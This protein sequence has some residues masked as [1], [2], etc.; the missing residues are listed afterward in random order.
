VNRLSQ[1]TRARAK[2]AFGY[3]CAVLRARNGAVTVSK[4]NFFV[5]NPKLCHEGER[6]RSANSEK[7]YRRRP[8]GG[9]KMPRY[10][11]ALND[12]LPVENAAEELPDD[13]AARELADLIEQELDR[14]GARRP[15]RIVVYND[16]RER[17]SRQT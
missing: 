15:F 6:R 3:R 7:I 13:K 5:R 16:R 9:R 14:C 2:L 8:A 11:Y 1:S 12:D 17:I 10:Y 4:E